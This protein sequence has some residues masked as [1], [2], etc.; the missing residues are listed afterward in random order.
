MLRVDGDFA[1]FRRTR[2][3]LDVIFVHSNNAGYLT[4]RDK[5]GVL[6]VQPFVTFNADHD[7]CFS[8]DFLHCSINSG[9]I[10]SLAMRTIFIS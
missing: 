2:F 7:F 6:Q 9:G 1:R 8:I 4:G 3:A 10:L 5:L